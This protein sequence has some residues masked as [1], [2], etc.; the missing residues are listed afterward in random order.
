VYV[1][2]IFQVPKALIIEVGYAGYIYTIRRQ[3]AE[4]H[5]KLFGEAE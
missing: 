4:N 3:K 5:A 2:N 1:R